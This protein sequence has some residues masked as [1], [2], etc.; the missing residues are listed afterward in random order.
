MGLKLLGGALLVAGLLF[1]YQF[2]RARRRGFVGPARRRVFREAQRTR[3]HL[4]CVGHAVGALICFIGAFLCLTG[5]IHFS[6]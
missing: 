5:S 2:V 6:H 4:A 3:F 1:R